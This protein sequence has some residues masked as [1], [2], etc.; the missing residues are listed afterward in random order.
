MQDRER[1]GRRFQGV[2]GGP[3]FSGVYR[4]SETFRDEELDLGVSRA[5]DCNSAAGVS[6]REHCHVI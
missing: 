3:S 1:I 2:E 5:R 4:I 6:E